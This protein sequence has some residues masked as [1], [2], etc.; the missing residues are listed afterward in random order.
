MRTLLLATS[1][2]TAAL[3]LVAAAPTAASCHYIEP[4]RIAE[5]P[6]QAW[7][8][9]GSPPADGH[10]GLIDVHFSDCGSDPG[11][12][13]CYHDATLTRCVGTDW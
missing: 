9:F 11:F 10:A 8:P 3:G 13:V 4:P 12:W 2:L 7:N 5:A 6:E 1:L